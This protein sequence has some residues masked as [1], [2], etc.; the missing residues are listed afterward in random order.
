MYKLFFEPWVG[1]NYNTKGY[2]GKKIMILGESHYCKGINV[3]EK[4]G[5]EHKEE[6]CKYLTQDVIHAVLGY[7]KGEGVHHRWMNSYTKFT[8]AIIG[9]NKSTE[10][11]LDFWDSV[12][13]YNYVQKS[14]KGPR[15]PPP[16]EYFNESEEVF[17]TLLKVHKPDLIIVWGKRLWENMSENGTQA[18][19]PIYDGTTEKFFFYN[20]EGKSIP[21]CHVHHPSASSFNYSLTPYLEEV[22]KKA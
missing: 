10:E 11:F 22:I 18:K 8:R 7:T 13:F 14:M 9:T 21:A 17:F 19:E 5:Q 6:A 4:C 15:I 12:V 20:I 16:P 1:K 2:L 3:C